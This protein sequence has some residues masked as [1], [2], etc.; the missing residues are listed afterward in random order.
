MNQEIQNKVDELVR[1]V[2][3]HSP[4]NAVSFKLFVNAYHFESEYQFRDAETLNRD[5][6]SMRALNGEFIK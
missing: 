3:A 1:L 4:E 2:R 5:S 6:I